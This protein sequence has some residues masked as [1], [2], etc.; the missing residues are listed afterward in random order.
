ML[1]LHHC[2]ALVGTSVPRPHEVAD[3][4]GNPPEGAPSPLCLLPSSLLGVIFGTAGFWKGEVEGG[5]VAHLLAKFH[6]PR[7][8]LM[9]R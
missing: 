2:L 9:I 4:T 1:A 3:A 5:L 8:G 6:G 7:R